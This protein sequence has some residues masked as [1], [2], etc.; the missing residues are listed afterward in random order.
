[1]VLQY[2]KVAFRSLCRDRVYT[3]VNLLGLS[4]GTTGA[5]AILV[6]ALYETSYDEHHAKADSVF[7]AVDRDYVRVAG[8]WA[9]VAKSQIPDVVEAVRLRHHHGRRTVTYGD[10]AVVTERA[11]FADPGVFDLFTGLLQNAVSMH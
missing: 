6:F 11:F 5:T 2:L 10:R 4:V 3:L 1:M 8:P 9:E 7:R